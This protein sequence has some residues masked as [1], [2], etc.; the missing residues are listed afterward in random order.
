MSGVVFAG[1]LL[2]AA[3]AAPQLTLEEEADAWAQ[4]LW[5]ATPTAAANWIEMPILDDVIL[6]SAHPSSRLAYRLQSTC[7]HQL[8]YGTKIPLRADREAFDEKAVRAALR[9]TKPARI[10]ADRVDPKAWMCVGFK[11][12]RVVSEY[13]GGAVNKMPETYAPATELKCQFIQNDGS[14]VDA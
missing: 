9:R 3:Q 4:C 10:E 12:G 7:W 14:V 13:L 1:L 6:S 5:N 11:S 2:A 8:G